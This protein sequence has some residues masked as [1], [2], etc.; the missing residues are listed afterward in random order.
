MSTLNIRNSRIL[1]VATA[2]VSV[3]GM[4]TLVASQQESEQEDD[5]DVYFLQDVHEDVRAQFQEMKAGPQPTGIND[6]TRTNWEI[7]EQV[8]GLLFSDDSADV[9]E[10]LSLLNEY[11][12]FVYWNKWIKLGPLGS[13]SFG[14]IPG[15]REV[16]IALFREKVDESGG[17]I[18]RLKLPREVD[19]AEEREI[20]QDPEKFEEWLNEGNPPVWTEIPA[21]LAA[22][23]PGDLDVHDLI[24][25]VHDPAQPGTT[26]LMLEMGG[27][28][29]PEATEFRIERLFM[30]NFVNPSEGTISYAFE[31][32]RGLGVCQSDEGFEALVR[33]LSLTLDAVL[34]SFVVE[35]IVA[36][37]ARALIHRERLE[38]IGKQFGVSAD[39]GESQPPEETLGSYNTRAPSWRLYFALRNLD[40][41]SKFEKRVRSA[42]PPPPVDRNPESTIDSDGAGALEPDPRSTDIEA[43]IDLDGEAEVSSLTYQIEWDKRI[44]QRE[45]YLTLERDE[46]GKYR[47]AWTDSDAKIHE[48][49][50][51]KV[52]DGRFSFDYQPFQDDIDFLHRTDGVIEDDKI[53]GRQYVTE[54][55]DIYARTFSGHLKPENPP[56]AQPVAI[57]PFAPLSWDDGLVD[58]LN[59]AKVW[60]DV[61]KRFF[62]CTDRDG[63][64]RGLRVEFDDDTNAA[65]LL[66]LLAEKNEGVR[67]RRNW[68]DRLANAGQLLPGCERLELV[69]YPVRVNRTDFRL[70]VGMQYEPVQGNSTD[71]TKNS[72]DFD[73]GHPYQLTR[74]ELAT[75]SLNIEYSKN[76]IFRTYWDPYHG[77]TML[78]ADQ[79]ETFLTRDDLYGDRKRYGNTFSHT[80]E[81]TFVDPVD[82]RLWMRYFYNNGEYAID[83]SLLLD[84]D[85]QTSRTMEIVFSLGEPRR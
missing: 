48:V 6:P 14:D 26:L 9:N 61:S 65:G 77:N 55:P 54:T 19:E 11:S 72:P 10:G 27:F 63:E 33:R 62:Q 53:T 59:K 68:R 25:E 36:Y 38:E 84:N 70:R 58:I 64:R 35:A 47:G 41:L 57:E 20:L 82:T 74:V 81:V 22:I 80:A 44:S 40:R 3:L 16:L 37:G 29:T 52:K 51:L 76:V 46:G 66:E 24:W 30:E 39:M 12:E 75:S 31:A 60:T 7:N 83:E 42:L 15:L 67:G 34:A 56:I 71:A 49:R 23:F 78:D 73:A 43:G 2:T 5:S 50:N 17:E 45:M 69:F 21:I 4:A 79:K 18:P 85:V 28:V 1:L 13:R 32:A 8:A